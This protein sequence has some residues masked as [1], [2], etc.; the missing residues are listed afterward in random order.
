MQK[1]KIF[2]SLILAL[3]A[4]ALSGCD[5]MER[6]TREFRYNV[7]REYDQMRY[8]ISNYIYDKNAKPP[9]PQASEAP[10]YEASYC[11]KVSS[12]VLCYARPQLTLRSRFI[13]MQGSGGEFYSDEIIYYDEFGDVVRSRDIDAAH[14][15]AGEMQS[16]SSTNYVGDAP[17]IAAA[18]DINGSGSEKSNTGN[19]ATSTSTNDSKDASATETKPKAAPVMLMP[20]Y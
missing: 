19:T 1:H 18:K 15:N 17:K 4:P 8:R 6:N 3:S 11:Y 9:Y 12:D 10:Y 7:D 16:R 13:G 20:R 14:R 2:T 5:S